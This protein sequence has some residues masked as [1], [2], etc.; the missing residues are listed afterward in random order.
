V[1]ER[2]VDQLIHHPLDLVTFKHEHDFA[3]GQVDAV[4]NDAGLGE[5][6]PRTPGDQFN[7]TGAR[8]PP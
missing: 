1:L 6:K 3:G 8:S 4:A 7:G 2:V 5:V